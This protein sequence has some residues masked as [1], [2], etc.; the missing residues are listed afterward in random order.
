MFLVSPS[1]TPVLDTLGGCIVGTWCH[2]LSSWGSLRGH[3]C[4]GA[5][6]MHAL[7][8]DAKDHCFVMCY[9]ER[10]CVLWRQQL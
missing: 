1:D 2:R 6:T 3:V 10:I 9:E 5:L 7:H 4:M 8:L